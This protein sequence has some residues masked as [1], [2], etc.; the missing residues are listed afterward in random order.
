MVPDISWGHW[1][2]T[3]AGRQTWGDVCLCKNTTFYLSWKTVKWRLGEPSLSALST[4]LAR[5]SGYALLRAYIPAQPAVLAVQDGR[6]WEQQPL[7]LFKPAQFGLAGQ[8]SAEQRRSLGARQQPGLRV[9]RVCGERWSPGA[10]PRP[11]HR[12]GVREHRERAESSAAA[13]ASQHG[14][15]GRS[16]RRLQ[17]EH[18]GHV[19]VRRGGGIIF[20]ILIVLVIFLIIF[21]CGRVRSLGLCPRQPSLSARVSWTRLQLA[22]DEKHGERKV[23]VSVQQRGA[24]RRPFFGGEGD[25]SAA[26]SCAQVGPKWG[27]CSSI[28]H[29]FTF[30]W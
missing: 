29:L 13:C 4:H 17:H 9:C 22:G 24:E 2:L 8:R 26:H 21:I 3:K 25:G 1:S 5:I 27:Q 28:S 14:E 30:S 6:G 19:D 12:A 23:R 11:R 7:R 16:A 15:Q 10:R 20:I 18:D